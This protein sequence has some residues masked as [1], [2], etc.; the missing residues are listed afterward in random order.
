MTLILSNEEISEL[1]TMPDTL[2]VLEDAYVEL[3]HGR[4]I[5]RRRSDSLAWG[6]L[7]D[8]VY[9]LKSMDGVA[10]KQGV[11][12]IRINSDVVTWPEVDGQRRRVKNP[13]AP[14]G[15][16][17]GL[18]LLF[19]TETGAPLAIIPDGVVQ[20]MRVGAT[21]GLGAKYLA[22][23]DARSVGILGSGWQAA[24]QLT[25]VCAV[26][27]IKT[28]KCFSPTGQ[29]RER[30][31]REMSKLLGIGVV[32]VRSA[33]EAF[34]GAD[35]ALCATSSIENVFFKDMIE[36]GMHVSSIKLP[37]V[38]AAAMKAADRLVVAGPSGTPDV[39]SVAGLE[40]MERS[41][42]KEARLEQEI[43]FARCP[44]LPQL[45]A[46]MVKGRQSDD[47]VTCFL[48]NLGMGYQ[49][50]AVGALLLDKARAAKAGREL[51]TEWFTEDVH[52]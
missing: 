18:V 37:E 27:D 22:R 23:A 35:I 1:L 9:G 46:G 20:R 6:A 29:N 8:S 11:A 38:E 31:C 2:A 49:F 43:D 24:T 15:R 26:R 19:S 7:P 50:A 40:W 32:P 21:N 47:E 33:R 14:G 42:T 3:A 34:E 28:I 16:F 48:N 10:P 30:F 52:P 36:P 45:I 4:G 41:A 5:T 25:A 17:T 51:P 44:T 13:V 39:V 12:A